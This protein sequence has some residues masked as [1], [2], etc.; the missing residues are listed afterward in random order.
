MGQSE[1]EHLLL[2]EVLWL[3]QKEL[4][5]EENLVDHQQLMHKIVCLV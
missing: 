1:V 2:Q 5:E 3:G 4:E